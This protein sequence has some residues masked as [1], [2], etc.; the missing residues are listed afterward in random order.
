MTTSRKDRFTAA[1]TGLASLYGRKLDA[2][3]ITAY[4]ALLRRID[5]D[6]VIAAIGAAPA[7]YVDWFPTGAQIAEIARDKARSRAVRHQADETRRQLPVPRVEDR[8]SP[9]N[10]PL[11]VSEHKAYITAADKP[12]EC[13]ARL[14]ECERIQSGRS[15]SAP[16]PGQVTEQR[17]KDFWATW[18]KA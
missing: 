14:W 9:G 10:P 8:Y 5:D 7:K 17:F 12:F 3:A 18:E 11:D 15:L 16:I 2:G 4:W 1:L 13:L 6:A